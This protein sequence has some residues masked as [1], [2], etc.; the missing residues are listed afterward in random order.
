MSVLIAP[1]PA[2]MQRVAAAKVAAEKARQLAEKEGRV[3]PAA[4]AVVGSLPE[5]SGTTTMT[6][7]TTTKAKTAWARKSRP[8][9]TRLRRRKLTPSSLPP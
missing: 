9:P 5:S 2:I 4:R 3:A 7:T 1:K 6:T 8:S